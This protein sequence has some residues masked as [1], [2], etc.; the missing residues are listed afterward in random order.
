MSRLE[1]SILFSLLVLIALLCCKQIF[2]CTL[3]QEEMD[4]STGADLVG[5][6]YYS[7]SLDGVQITSAM[8]QNCLN[9]MHL[10]GGPLLVVWFSSLG[11][12]SC[13]EYVLN[14]T[15][16]IE[17]KGLPIL[18]IGADYQLQSSIDGIV[19]IDRNDSLGLS[20]EELKI[21]FM[22]VYDNEVR[23]IFFPSSK[24]AAAF[25]MYLEIV[26]NRYGNRG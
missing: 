1:K 25:E 20:A 23:H 17:G 19:Y 4:I 12:S 5:Q 3:K 10:T 22:F 9:E 2:N 18:F 21:P 24:N 11:C 13:N 16:E 7:C 6:T 8:W 15:A 26:T 14:K